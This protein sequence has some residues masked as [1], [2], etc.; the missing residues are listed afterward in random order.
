MAFDYSSV[1]IGFALDADGYSYHGPKLFQLFMGFLGPTFQAAAFFCYLGI[2]ASMLTKKYVYGSTFKISTMDIRL[3]VQAFLISVPL[4]IVILFGL[5]LA[6]NL[7]N[8]SWLYVSWSYLAA[9]VPVVN[10]VVHIAFNPTVRCHLVQ[11]LSRKQ[12]KAQVIVITTSR[13]L[14]GSAQSFTGKKMCWC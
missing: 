14:A 1:D 12:P 13:T 2:L 8:C 6:D 10:L 9:L 7:M 11:L 4:A 5:V 3:I